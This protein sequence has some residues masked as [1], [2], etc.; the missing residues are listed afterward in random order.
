MD[1]PEMDYKLV[2]TKEIYQLRIWKKI[3]NKLIE[4]TKKTNLYKSV[5]E[6]FPDAEL[7][8]VKLSQKDKD[9]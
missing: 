2:K 7:I 3:K 1:Q 8:D 4:D 9:K 5:L 6:Y